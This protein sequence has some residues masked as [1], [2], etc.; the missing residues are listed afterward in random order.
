M[1]TSLKALVA[2]ATGAAPGAVDLSPRAPLGHQANRL[3][4]AW[5]T[6]RHL[7]VKEFLIPDEQHAAPAREFG[8]LQLLA[9][10]DIA[11]QPVFFEPALGPVVIYEFMEGEMWDRRRPTPIDLALLAD[12]WLK[13]NAVR[14]NNLWWSHGYDRT[15]PD[16]AARLRARLEAYSDWAN[17]EFALGRRAADMCLNVLESRAGLVRELAAYNPLLCF[18]RADPRFANVIQ[19]P[20]GRLGLVDWEDSGLRDPARDLADVMTHPNQEDLLAPDAWQAFLE[21]DLA[22]QGRVDAQ[23]WHRTHF[24]LALFPI[25][26]LTV[27]MDQGRGRAKTRINATC[28]TQRTSP[29]LA[30]QTPTHS[31][32]PT[33]YTRSGRRCICGCIY[34]PSTSRRSSTPSSPSVRLA[35][36]PA[37][38]TETSGTTRTFWS[39]IICINCTAV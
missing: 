16:V 37:P 7:I 2:A 25:F 19:R 29:D 23:L 6:Q 21:P 27:I 33:P 1:D 22:V 31:P 32:H 3:Y 10:L 35:P 20:D 12:I 15:L 11:P 4:D 39:P 18:C 24:Y 28:Q 17:A 8:A 26:W 36:L 30:G 34:F 13:M 38:V 5:V 9:S 14:A